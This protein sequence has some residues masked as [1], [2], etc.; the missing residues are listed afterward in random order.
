VNINTTE[1]DAFVAGNTV[2]FTKSLPDY[3]P[4]DGWVLSY[5]FVKDGDQ[6]LVT[7]T[8]NGDGLH[9]ITISA[10]DSAKF[11]DGIYHYQASVSKGGERY[12]VVN[13]RLEVKPNF[14]TQT[15][16]FDSR[17]HVKKV[18]D[19]L[20]AVFEK[21]ATKDQASYTIG[22]KSISRL[23]P[24]ELINWKNHYQRLYNA[25][26]KSE[27]IKN[28]EAAGNKIRVRF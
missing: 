23:T 24:A 18:L 25:E 21:K 8:D 2:K 12:Q 15:K 17:S 3:L 27:R 19:A 4:A 1:P 26:L 13:N 7:A 10:A 14:A 6:Q 9:L 5:A 28:G 16:G 22:D 11:K 20:E